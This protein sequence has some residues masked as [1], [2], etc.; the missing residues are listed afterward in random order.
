MRTER[1][2]PAIDPITL[3]V[4]RN[5]L[6]F[7]T[8]E[9]AIALRRSAYSTNIKTRN[10]YSCAFFNR[11]LKTVAQA[12][13]QPNHLSAFEHLV[14]EAIGRYAP[15]RLGLGDALVTNEPYPGGAHLNDI[16]LISPV[17]CDGESPVP[18]APWTTMVFPLVRCVWSPRSPLATAASDSTSRA[19][20][21]NGRRSSTRPTAR[22]S[23][24]VHACSRLSWARMCQSM[25]D[26]AGS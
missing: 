22:R 10:D 2:G 21:A 8:E 16:T 26:S 18:R 6:L 4:V 20:I 23:H 12:L 13:G 17:F 1:G 19:R 3:E 9:M 11:D 5:A 15:R 7:A 24:R 14:P 25:R